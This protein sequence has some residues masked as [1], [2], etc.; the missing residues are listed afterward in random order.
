[1]DP[2]DDNDGF[3]DDAEK[4]AGT[5][6]KDP[7]SK[8]ASDTDKDTTADKPSVTAN[9]DGSVTVKVGEDNT[10]GTIH[11]TGEDGSQQTVTIV[12]DPTT[13]EWTP[14]G[15]LPDGVTVDKDGTVTI[16]ANK[17]EDGST[18]TATG[19]DAKGNVAK[20]ST[21]AKPN[22][23]TD[24]GA[25]QPPMSGQSGPAGS[26]T[27]KPSKGALPKTGTETST[28]GVYGLVALGLAGFLALGKSKREDKE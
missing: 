17:V 18:V 22:Q 5:D 28:K 9:E 19:K 12:K 27:V 6:S 3:T 8:P 1:M 25:G 14:K 13:G 11:Y 26:T 24:P 10:T 20:G 21:V 4:D 15:T 7:N 23:T 2:D 16:P